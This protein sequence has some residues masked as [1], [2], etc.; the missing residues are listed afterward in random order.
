MAGCL[1]PLPA[2]ASYDLAHEH[3]Y[4]VTLQL[5]A[6]SCYTTNFDPDI[7]GRASTKQKAISFDIKKEII[8]QKEK[9]EENSHRM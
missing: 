9:G 2:A 4:P 8:A 1:L 5:D 6:S 7:P 3:F